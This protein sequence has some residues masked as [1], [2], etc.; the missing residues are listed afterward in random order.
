MTALTWQ[1]LLL[2]AVAYFGGCCIGC[3]LR[4]AFGGRRRIADEA[5]LVQPVTQAP[6]AVV[7][8]QPAFRTGTPEEVAAAAARSAARP[9]IQATEPFRRAE[10][11]AD[12]PVEVAAAPQEEEHPHDPDQTRRFHQALTG[13]GR[14][15][16][17]AEAVPVAREERREPPKEIKREEKKDEKEERAVP[18]VAAVELPAV[19]AKPA[20]EAVPVAPAVHDDL[21]IIRAIDAGVE[22][23]LN[24]L[25]VTSFAAIAKWTAADVARVNRA[26]GF[27]DRIQ[28]E[29]WIEQAQILAAGGETQ[30]ARRLASGEIA[31]AR[32]VE[33]E[34]DAR[35]A[36]PATK[37]EPPR[38]EDLA[39]DTQ[40][41]EVAAAAAAAA[42][43]AASLAAAAV[44]SMG[45]GAD[46]DTD[47]DAAGRDAFVH[48]GAQAPAQAVSALV[49]DAANE[50]TGLSEAPRRP[51]V[52]SVPDALQRI[53]GIN[54]EIEALL[55][56]QG[57]T[58]YSQIASWGATDI[59]RIDHMLGQQGRV[60]RENWIEQAQ[61]LSKGGDTT[62]SREFDRDHAGEADAAAGSEDAA[63]PGQ[64][65]S[66]RT[67]EIAGLRSVRSEGL[68]AAEGLPIPPPE[69]VVG[70]IQPIGEPDDLKRIRGIGVLIEKKLNSMGVTAYAHIANWTASDIDRV[71]QVLDFKGRIERENWVEQARILVSGGQTEFSRRADRMGLYHEE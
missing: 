11:P 9:I 68:R 63:E 62:Y 39:A 34:G 42:T 46:F 51:A 18:V 58:R 7:H 1:S 10:P 44:A 41:K 71:S 37:D 19:K 60:A 59:D 3:M 6:A 15:F 5:V 32:A 17:A 31:A 64:D 16:A 21:K 49:P 56:T 33:D 52:G 23:R 13:E 8:S 30:Y 27:K 38:A 4:R 54:A 12:V 35:A 50:N 67:S 25:G 53:R 65:T 40:A 36:V 57:M 22:E 70:R 47:S 28:H 55:N 2:L 24:A 66:T 69:V 29:N 43:A 20:V 61:I 14:D 26:L 45:H 48:A